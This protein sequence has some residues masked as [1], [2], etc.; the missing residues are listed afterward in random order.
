M[1]DAIPEDKRILRLKDLS[2]ELKKNSSKIFKYLH[3]L[4]KV[5]VLWDKDENTVEDLWSQL[6]YKTKYFIYIK[7][8]NMIK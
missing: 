5:N 1:L 7:K 8:Q 3:P 6:D 4:D 2:T